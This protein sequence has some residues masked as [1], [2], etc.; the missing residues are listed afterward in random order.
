MSSSSATAAV[1]QVRAI[2]LHFVACINAILGAARAEL[3]LNPQASILA[4]FSTYVC[5]LDFWRY[6]GRRYK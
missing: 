2:A 1:S 4:I 6:E 5:W 3:A